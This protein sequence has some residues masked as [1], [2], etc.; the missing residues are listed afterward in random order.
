MARSI[1]AALRENLQKRRIWRWRAPLASIPNCRRGQQSSRGRLSSARGA[2]RGNGGPRSPERALGP[3]PRRLSLLLC[4]PWGLCTPSPRGGLLSSLP[5]P[6]FPDGRAPHPTAGDPS[7]ASLLSRAWQAPTPQHGGGSL[8]PPAA[9]Q[10]QPHLSPPSHTPPWTHRPRQ[11]GLKWHGRAR[12]AQATR[13]PS[14]SPLRVWGRVRQR[15]PRA[16]LT[17]STCD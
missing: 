7:P 11:V 3:A 13:S 9:W 14:P 2:G 10:T 17:N 8:G 16:R 5:A 1:L 12:E 6:R 4:A 15:R